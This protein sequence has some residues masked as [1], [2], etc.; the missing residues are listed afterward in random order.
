M[1]IPTGVSVTRIADLMLSHPNI[2]P[3]TPMLLRFVNNILIS[4]YLPKPQNKVTSLWLIYT[5]MRV[6][7]MCPIKKPHKVVGTLQKGLSV[8]VID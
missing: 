3:N 8:W 2:P 4:M 5:A 1:H 7:D 6:V